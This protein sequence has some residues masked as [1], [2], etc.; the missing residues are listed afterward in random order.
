MEAL[1]QKKIE[2]PDADIGEEKKKGE[3]EGEG[4]GEGKG[5]EKG[6]RRGE[7]TQDQLIKG[8]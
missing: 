4:N 2:D 6:G 5:K 7:V 1:L 3:G 8:G